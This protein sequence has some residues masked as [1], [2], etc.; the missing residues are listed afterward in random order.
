M[1]DNGKS[2]DRAREPDDDDDAEQSHTPSRKRRAQFSVR[3]SREWDAFAE[4]VAVLD[5]KRVQVK[6]SFAFAFVEGALVKALREG[7]WLLLDEINL[8]PSAALQRLLGE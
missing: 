7:H 8:A 3:L 6:K 1:T 4:R 5:Q 2:S